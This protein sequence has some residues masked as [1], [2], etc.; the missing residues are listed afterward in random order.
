MKKKLYLQDIVDE[1][2]RGVLSLFVAEL[3]DVLSSDK[4][5]GEEKTIEVKK[6]MQEWIIGCKLIP[7]KVKTAP[8]EL[9]EKL[10]RGEVGFD[11][12]L[13]WMMELK[14]CQS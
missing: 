8:K 13:E 9:S 2:M 12:I 10:M 4:L 1:S 5:S 11:A 6:V 7:E 14:K 3:Q